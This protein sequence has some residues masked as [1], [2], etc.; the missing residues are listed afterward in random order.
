MKIVPLNL[1]QNPYKICIGQSTLSK[2]GAYLKTLKIGQDAVIITNPLIKKFYGK[3]IDDGLKKNGLSV[4]FFEVPAGEPS[5]EATIALKLIEKI[6]AYGSLKQIFIVALGGGVIGD[7]AGYVAA[8]YKRGI[9]YVQVPTTF[10]AQVD[11][12]IGGKVAVN[13]PTGKNLVGA[14]HQP[15]VVWS[16]IAVLSS[17]DQRQIRNGLAEALKYGV[18]Y[19]KKLFHYIA[20]HYNEL[21]GADYAALLKVVTRS[22]QIK[23]EIVVEDEKE[24]KGIRTILNFGHTIGHA[25]ESA[26]KYKLYQHGEAIALGMRIAADISHQLGMLDSPSVALLNEVLSN[27]GLPETTQK[28]RLTDILKIMDHDKKFIN[29]QNRFVLVTE[30]GKV[31]VVEGVAM[32]VIKRATQKYMD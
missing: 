31:K 27:I 15:K 9:P 4:K 8:A 18:I 29:G 21:L 14:F 10:L 28:L 19:D 26:G 20:Q 1:K 12:S 24:T 32:D 6:D 2:L 22:S 23:A 11:S 25:I 13:L 5:K 3:S 30:I 7:L 16:D 17:L